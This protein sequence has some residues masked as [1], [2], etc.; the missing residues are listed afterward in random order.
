MERLEFNYF[1][2]NTFADEGATGNPQ[3]E[4]DSKGTS[5]STPKSVKKPSEKKSA[6]KQESGGIEIENFKTFDPFAEEG[7]SGE[8]K[9]S[10]DNY[11]HI[12][13]QLQG[14]PSKFDPKRI[15]KKIKKDFA[16]NGTVI[17]DVT[18]GE[19]IQLQGD[20]RKVSQ[21]FLCDKQNGLGLDAKTIKVHGF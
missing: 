4:N 17:H 9:D 15:L 16:C 19:V 21:E 14:I 7:V 11:I 10:T 13:I 6:A 5:S 18:M 8:S 1:V 3:L 20:Q 12:R 2:Q